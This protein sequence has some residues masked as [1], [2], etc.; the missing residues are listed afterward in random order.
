MRKLIGE[1]EKCRFYRTSKC[2]EYEQMPE[3]IKKYG[4]GIHF[5]NVVFKDPMKNSNFITEYLILGK[6]GEAIGEMT[7]RSPELILKRILEFMIP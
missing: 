3:Y 4:E 1:N 7:E 6:D 2:K 5:I